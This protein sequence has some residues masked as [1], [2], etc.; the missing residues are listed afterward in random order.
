MGTAGGFVFFKNEILSGNPE[1]FFVLHGDIMT[2]FPLAPM[3]DFHV[4][5]GKEITIMGTK[6]KSN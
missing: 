3:M 4:R 2:T 6:V 5:H 1:Y